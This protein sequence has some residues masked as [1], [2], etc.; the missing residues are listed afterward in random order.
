MG[1]S[2]LANTDDTNCRV[3]THGAKPNSAWENAHTQLVLKGVQVQV[4]AS[5]FRLPSDPMLK[6]LAPRE[7]QSLQILHFTDNQQTLPFLFLDAAHFRD[8]LV[9]RHH[10]LPPIPGRPSQSCLPG[11][12]G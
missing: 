7:G 4:L 12:A 1:T 8:R 10:S 11:D 3:L 5:H 2:F 9:G 6:I